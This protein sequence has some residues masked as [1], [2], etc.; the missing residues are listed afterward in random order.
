MIRQFSLPPSLPPSL[1][2]AFAPRERLTLQVFTN[3]IIRDSL[4]VE[5]F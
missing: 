3:C 1:P 5:T 2:S 4:I